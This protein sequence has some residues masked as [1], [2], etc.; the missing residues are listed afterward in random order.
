MLLIGQ[1][2][3]FVRHSISSASSIKIIKPRG[4]AGTGK[5]TSLRKYIK[6]SQNGNQKRQIFVGN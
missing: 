2:A 4:E 1:E 6:P 3:C 5:P